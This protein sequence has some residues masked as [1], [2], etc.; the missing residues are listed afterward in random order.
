MAGLIYGSSHFNG[1]E[2]RENEFVRG[3]NFTIVN[4]RERERERERL[5]VSKLNLIFHAEIRYR[6]IREIA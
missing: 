6:A 4:E 3:E 2:I 1:A 5:K